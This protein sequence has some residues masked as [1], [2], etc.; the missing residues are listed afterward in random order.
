MPADVSGVNS[1][2]ARRDAILESLRGMKARYNIEVPVL[3]VRPPT[4]MKLKL[5][6]TLHDDGC[7]RGK[8]TTL[9]HRYHEQCP[10]TPSS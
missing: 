10:A 3:Q 5:A 1:P 7:V 2:A 8:A 4:E 6:R 9:Q